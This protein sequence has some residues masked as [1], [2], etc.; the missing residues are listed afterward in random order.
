M[1]V[2]CLPSRREGCPNVVLE[3]LASGTPVVGSA[4]GGVPELITGM[5]GI[6]V[7]PGDAE[8]LAAG[9]E[10]AL[11]LNW[12]RQS[13]RDSVEFLSWEQVGT[14]YFHILQDAVD[15]FGKCEFSEEMRSS[16]RELSTI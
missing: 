15:S 16:Q 4:V 6:L 14:N 5:N 8:A 7:P 11:E 3:A 13:L 1:D 2:L 10:R 12:D 9:L